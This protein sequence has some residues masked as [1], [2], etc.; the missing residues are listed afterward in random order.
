MDHE[1]WLGLEAAGYNH[2]GKEGCRG[3]ELADS[4]ILP[5]I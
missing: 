2:V 4:P 3:K 1:V 5:E